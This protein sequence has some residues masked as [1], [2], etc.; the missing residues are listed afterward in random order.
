M[1]LNVKESKKN[2]FVVEIKGQ[3]HSLC[4][5]LKDE[6]QKDK[7]LKNAGYFVEHPQVGVPTLLVET[8]GDKTPQKAIADACKRLQKQNEK[9]LEL[10][11]KI[12]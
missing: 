10:F 3:G 5:S 6:L 4:G 11:K 1:E 8:S 12:K 7:E 2:R 9:F